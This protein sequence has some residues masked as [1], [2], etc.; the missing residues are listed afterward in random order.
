MG[1]RFLHQDNVTGQH[2]SALYKAVQTPCEFTIFLWRITILVY[3][4]NKKD[5]KRQTRTRSIM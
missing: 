1:Y 5:Y 3:K 4:T 2:K